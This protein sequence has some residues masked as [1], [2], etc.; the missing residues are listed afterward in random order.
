MIIK[1]KYELRERHVHTRVFMGPETTHMTLCGNLMF[2]LSEF[3]TF[4]QC[5]KNGSMLVKGAE[6]IFSDA[7]GGS[8]S[9]F[10]RVQLP[11]GESD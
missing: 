4:R 11:P 5:L 1:V 6:V 8:S 10:P 9:S 2:N 7:T 3:D